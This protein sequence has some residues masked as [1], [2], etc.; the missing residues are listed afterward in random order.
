LNSSDAADPV[1]LPE[2]PE[3]TLNQSDFLQLL[4]AQLSSQ[5]P[6][7]PVSDTQFIAQMAQFSA[8]QETTTMQESVAS[9]QANSLLGQTVEVQ[10][11]AGTTSSGVVSSV[12][13]QSGSPA[14]IVNGQSYTLDQVQAISQTDTQTDGATPP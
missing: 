2:L 13:Y 10:N 5:N 6:M 8:L 1:Q 4:V 9:L 3:Q 12:L 14:V 11:D 7:D